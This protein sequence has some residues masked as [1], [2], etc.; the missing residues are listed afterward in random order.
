M[1]RH[2]ELRLMT[3]VAQALPWDWNVLDETIKNEKKLRLIQVSVGSALLQTPVRTT[4]TFSSEE[5]TYAHNWRE[6]V[7]EKVRYA[8]KPYSH[9]RPLDPG[10][11]ID[12][13]QS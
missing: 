11:D 1:P 13:E 8:I 6:L 12:N 9:I 4:I 3:Q 2:N 7:K 5:L 10:K